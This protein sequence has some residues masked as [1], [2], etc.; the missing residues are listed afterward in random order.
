MFGKLQSQ[1]I[2]KLE[3]LGYSIATNSCKLAVTRALGLPGGHYN[4]KTGSEGAC[5]AFDMIDAPPHVDIECEWSIRE[6]WDEITL[7]EVKTL[8]KMKKANLHFTANE[9]T[10][11]R[12]LG[13]KYRLVVVVLN[14][15]RVIWD[16]LERAYGRASFV[17]IQYH[18]AY[19]APNSARAS[20][21]E[22][23][24]APMTVEDTKMD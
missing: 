6:H 17:G 14:S 21:H 22:T 12:L 3:S 18:F 10:L 1:G 8:S 9:L 4:P 11:A 7:L 2:A 23:S 24:M 20:S 19:R 5:N 16:D 13:K 15:D